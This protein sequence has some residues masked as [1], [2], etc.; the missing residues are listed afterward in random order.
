MGDATT[1]ADARAGA[2]IAGYNMAPE[3]EGYDIGHI[4]NP[5]GLDA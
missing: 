1:Y 2:Q 5:D 4:A 3:N